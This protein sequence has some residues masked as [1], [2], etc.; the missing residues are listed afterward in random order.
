[1]TKVSNTSRYDYL[2]RNKIVHTNQLQDA[3][4]I[5]RRSTRALN[6]C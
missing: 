4:A 6:T 2:L 1:M 5:A 3:L